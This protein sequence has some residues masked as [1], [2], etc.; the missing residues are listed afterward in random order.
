MAT[1]KKTI[2]KKKTTNKTQ[3]QPVEVVH[4]NEEQADIQVSSRWFNIKIDDINVKTV[5][6]V[7]M[8]L[9]A[10]VAVVGIVL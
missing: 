4:P 5:I 9:A 8:M 6:I 7:A 10:V 1:A 3:P 2:S